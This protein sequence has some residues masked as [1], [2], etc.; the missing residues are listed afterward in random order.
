MEKQTIYVGQPSD[1]FTVD[2]FNLFDD[3][4]LL[5]ITN[6]NTEF[7]RNDNQQLYTVQDMLILRV[8][9]ITPAPTNTD[10]QITVTLYKV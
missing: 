6:Q 10:K 7:L 4:L 8:K 3:W 1:V 5:F 9:K 2:I